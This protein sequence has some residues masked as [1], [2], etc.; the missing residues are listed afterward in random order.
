MIHE[1]YHCGGNDWTVGASIDDGEECMVK[2]HTRSD[3]DE[4]E[5]VDA[6][7]QLL[8]DE[9]GDSNCLYESGGLFEIVAVPDDVAQ[10]DPDPDG[11]VVLF[12]AVCCPGLES[13]LRE[14]CEAS[15]GDVVDE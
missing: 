2:L 13:D 12:G 3:S 8:H 10:A 15:D 14:V 4:Q 9:F 5:D 1:F 7:G 11:V 6:L